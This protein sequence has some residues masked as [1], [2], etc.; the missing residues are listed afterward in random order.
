[1][2]N[3]PPPLIAMLAVDVFYAY[4]VPITTVS[5]VILCKKTDRRHVV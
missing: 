1:M 5:V 2:Q 3:K 4:D